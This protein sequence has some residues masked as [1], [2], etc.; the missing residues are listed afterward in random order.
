MADHGS[1]FWARRLRIVAMVLPFG[2]ER[3]SSVHSSGVVTAAPG[4]A[5]SEYGAMNVWP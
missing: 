2:V 1:V 4:L 5:R 3:P